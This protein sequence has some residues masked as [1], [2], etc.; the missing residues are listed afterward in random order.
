MLDY[1]AVIY[2]I[3]T[4]RFNILHDN[5]DY[6]NTT[7]H[8][9][10]APCSGGKTHSAIQYVKR[11]HKLKK[12]VI[13]VPTLALADQYTREC[14]KH[15]IP[16]QCIS[17]KTPIKMEDRGVQKK[18]DDQPVDDNSE[19]K[20]VKEQ[21]IKTVKALNSNK[22]KSS[23]LIITQVSFEQLPKNLFND[24]WTVIVDE[25]PNV[26]EYHSLT[27]PHNYRM[28]T[29]IV[30]VTDT[31]KST[32]YQLGIKDTKKA[33][34][35]IKEEQDDIDDLYKPVVQHL[36]DGD[37][38]LI[39]AGSWKRVVNKM[40]EEEEIYSF[41]KNTFHFLF[42][43][44]PLLYTQ[45][46]TVII[47]GANF[48]YSMLYNL[49]STYFNVNFVENTGITKKLRYSVH[50][51]GERLSITY[52]QE[53]D[54][55]R[56]QAQLIDKE[57]GEYGAVANIRLAERILGSY[58][59]ICALNTKDEILRPRCWFPVPIK[60]QGLNNYMG[61]NKIYFGA[62]LNRQ[63]KHSIMLKDYGFSN[64]II[65]DS[66]QNE[67]AYQII[68]RTSI[69]DINSDEPVMVVVQDKRSADYIARC[70]PGCTIGLANGGKKKVVRASRT[71]NYRKNKL[72]LLIE[73][74]KMAEMYAI[75][76]KDETG[77]NLDCHLSNKK[78]G[79]N[80]N[81]VLD[82]NLYLDKYIS[83]ATPGKIGAS[84]FFDEL[85]QWH[86]NNRIDRK[87]DNELFNEG[88]FINN[89]R[90]KDNFQSTQL[91][92]LDIDGG[93]LNHTTCHNILKKEKL[94]HVMMNSA[95]NGTGPNEKYRVILLA[96]MPMIPE[97]HDLVYDYII[98][99]FAKNHYYTHKTKEDPVDFIND[100]RAI[101]P[102]AKISGIDLSKKNGASIFYAPC[103]VNGREEHA[104]FLRAFTSERDIKYHSI[105]VER[106]IKHS[107]LNEKSVELIYEEVEKAPVQQSAE[108]TDTS[109]NPLENKASYKKVQTILSEMGP[110]H[111][112]YNATR[113]G[114]LIKYWPSQDKKWDII[115]E[116][117]RKQCDKNALSQAIKYAG[118][119][120]Y[121]SFT[122]TTKKYKILT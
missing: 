80:S 51:N 119:S 38:V 83:E 17:S 37:Q 1:W 60:S 63:P 61:F 9:V 12:I 94:T 77:L 68:C 57:T 70:F 7:I 99:M 90:R 97:V 44:T 54:Y 35:L 109:E 29:D 71:D 95:S 92:V 52:L 56:Y 33:N 113:I 82:I 100:K 59:V 4:R 30:E 14:K 18:K 40:P 10:D 62:A 32:L 2:V 115:R 53:N 117:E 93:D 39:D 43:K 19:R 45:F 72:Q 69:R 122:S 114:G 6:S 5:H 120:G 81:Y 58:D 118:L 96:D 111:R 11:A 91:I 101:D 79:Y 3:L 86:N 89:I 112:S 64:E 49:W 110:G 24:S 23:V 34:S 88:R 73:N 15:H 22:S 78:E 16:V 48:K 65:A 67:N 106:V 121:G 76:S 50:P 28:L 46:G 103:I 47:M 116:L 107:Q 25:I 102:L 42:L 108:K 104:F 36:L 8:Y 105:K 84:A 55:S 21:I 66:F 87:E 26:D 85:S 98:D 31:L 74:Y 13:T 20:S 75:D 27:V 41:G